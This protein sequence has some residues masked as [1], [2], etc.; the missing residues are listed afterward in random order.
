MFLATR[1]FRSERESKLRA[2]RVT[3]TQV[4]GRNRSPYLNANGLQ[5][6]AS[7]SDRQRMS[8]SIEDAGGDRN[9]VFS[10]SAC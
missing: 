9:L 2:K 7:R 4:A 5:K 3:F 6:L 10:D 1:K 8:V